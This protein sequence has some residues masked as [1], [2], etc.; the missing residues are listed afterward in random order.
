[1]RIA[2]GVEYDGTRYHGW[3]RQNTV[4]SIQEEVEKALSKVASQAISVTCA[5]RT[6]AGVH[7]IEQVVHFDTDAKRPDKA[8]V[9]GSNTILPNDIRILWAKPVFSQ[10]N[11]RYTA[12]ARQYR[13]MIYNSRVS[14]A[15]LRHRAAWYRLP[16]DEELMHEAG[17]YLIGEHDF[18]SFRGSGCQSKSTMRNMMF[19][20]V[21]RNGN[22]INVDIK[23][24]AFLQ[25]MVRN[26]VGVLIEIG[27]KKKPIR[28]IKEVLEACDR[29]AAASTADPSGLYLL[30][31]DYPKS[32]S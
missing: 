5:G 8:W 28:W 10:F 18:S 13:Y 27:A 29:K 9:L 22:M 12:G 3:Q 4:S 21:S 6:D 15:L 1:M 14:S 32:E 19:L 23:A 25:H 30:K 7:A 26:I 20:E 24:N 16:L 11:A 17:Q 2:L 31:V